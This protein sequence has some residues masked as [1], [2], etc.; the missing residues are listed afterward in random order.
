MLHAEKC[1][2]LIHALKEL[3][4]RGDEEGHSLESFKNVL[5]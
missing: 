5:C 4:V 2:I 1:M 3:M